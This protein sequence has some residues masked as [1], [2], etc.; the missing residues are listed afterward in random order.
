[1]LSKLSV[2]LTFL[3]LPLLLALAVVD[4]VC[5]PFAAVLTGVFGEA[6]LEIFGVFALGDFRMLGDWRLAFLPW[7]FFA[8]VFAIFP[9]VRLF[10]VGTLCAL[11]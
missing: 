7:L 4:L 6:N 3:P 5:L 1:M 9:V 2:L 11:A 8:L 10:G